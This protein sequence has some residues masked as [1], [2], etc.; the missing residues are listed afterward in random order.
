MS[1]V[2]QNMSM[3]INEFAEMR[4]GSCNSRKR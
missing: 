3:N 2:T 4:P 1:D